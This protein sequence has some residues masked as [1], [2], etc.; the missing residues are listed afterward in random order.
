MDSEIFTQK[1]FKYQQKLENCSDSE[2]KELYLKRI[3]HYNNQIGGGCNYSK[4][5]I[6]VIYTTDELYDFIDIIEKNPKEAFNKLNTYFPGLSLKLNSEELKVLE[7]SSVSLPS[8]CMVPRTTYTDLSITKVPSIS[9]TY[10]LDK[11]DA[12]YAKTDLEKYV[13]DKETEINKVKELMDTM[14]KKLKEYR[15]KR[16]KEIEDVK[17]CIDKKELF[18]KMKKEQKEFNE[19]M[20][21][22]FTKGFFSKDYVVTTSM[23]S[24]TLSDCRKKKKDIL[25]QLKLTNLKTFNEIKTTLDKLNLVFVL[26][27]ENNKIT[28]IHKLT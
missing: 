7:C 15:D 24:H 16:I 25:S 10:I 2:K 5:G 26:D 28:E 12:D 4:K 3:D 13:T 6:Y 22:F 11:N 1:L 20:K 14:V 18:D 21:G 9:Y 23:T 17:K 27:P 8:F 19:K